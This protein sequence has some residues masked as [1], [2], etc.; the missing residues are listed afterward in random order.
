MLSEFL[1]FDAIKK[2][3]TVWAYVAFASVR[4]ICE[5]TKIGKFIMY[6]LAYY[7][8]RTSRVKCIDSNMQNRQ[9]PGQHYYR[10]A[11]Q[12]AELPDKP[13]LIEAD[14]CIYASVN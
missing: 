9:E 11:C 2:Y 3:Q 13:K 8:I 6:D 4:R 14:L 7:R 5:K 12:S 10:D 1:Y